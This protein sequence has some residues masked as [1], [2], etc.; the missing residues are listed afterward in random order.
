MM[1]DKTF[2][3]ALN[4][5]ETLVKELEQGDIDLKDAVDKYNEGM[6]LSKHCHDLLDNAEKVIVKMMK[7][8][9]LTDFDE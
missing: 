4:E 7:D 1:S 8:D 2:E 5:L 3:Q 9:E 6:K